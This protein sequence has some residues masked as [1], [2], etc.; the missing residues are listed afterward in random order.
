MSAFR[1]L[2]DVGVTRSSATKQEGK[3][4]PLPLL[5]AQKPKSR[6]PGERL[7]SHRNGRCRICS[8]AAARGALALVFGPTPSGFLRTPRSS[9][10]SAARGHALYR[11][12]AAQLLVNVKRAGGWGEREK[13]ALTQRQIAVGAAPPSRAVAFR[14]ALAGQR[15]AHGNPGFPTLRVYGGGPGACA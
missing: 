12:S 15:A 8:P 4:P 3:R 6:R 11:G 7:G 9:A 1:E 10:F 2:G 5:P 14:Q 13:P